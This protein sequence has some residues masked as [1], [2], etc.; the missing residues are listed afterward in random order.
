MVN[1]SCKGYGANP[2]T[3]QIQIIAPN[4]SN[5]QNGASTI[6]Y[7]PVIGGNY[8]ARCTHTAPNMNKTVCETPFEIKTRERICP[9]N[10]EN[11]ITFNG[12]NPNN[13]VL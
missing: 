1:A 8:I 6:T 10:K 4:L 9:T 5:N 13:V 11:I 12:R 7:H 2:D 3:A